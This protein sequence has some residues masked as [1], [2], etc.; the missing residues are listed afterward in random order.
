MSKQKKVLIVYAT[1]GMGHVTAA[2]ATEQAFKLKYPDVETKNI[3][4]IDFAP[5]FY[6]KI[7]VDGYNYVSAKKPK[8]WGWLYRKYNNRFSQ[9]LPTMLS[10]AAISRKF[11]P[12]IKEF[13]PDFII[14]AHPLPMVLVSNSREKN[15]IDIL[16]SIIITD[17]GCHSFWINKGVN[18]Y[19]CAAE[20]VKKC[21]GGYGVDL[22]SAVVSGIPIEPKFSKQEDKISLAKKFGLNLERPTLLIVGGQ[23]SFLNLK[24]IID[25]INHRNKDIQ[26]IVISG[27][28]KALRNAIEKSDLSKNNN[29]KIFDFVDNMQE[30]MTVS[31]LIFSKAGGLTVSEC[32]AKG[33][34]MVIN[35]V[36]PGQEEDNVNYLVRHNAAVK[37]DSFSGI[38]EE[39]N[40]LLANPAKLAE[41]KNNCL[42][43]GRP[44][45]A[46]NLVD[47][48]YEKIQ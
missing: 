30:F 17:F 35:K 10:V 23:F 7:F 16:S 9:K 14:S 18:Y 38:I 26:F 45:S 13:N 31:D 41:M 33:L 19:F 27:R 32:M 12:F 20:D 15:I 4:V 8:F 42:K 40:N 2:K 48:V 28:D 34:P 6:K 47:F 39:V 24:M 11:I 43:I 44:N 3:D 46:E 29:I 37:A 21:L 22:N 1:G 5:K 36:I 25:G